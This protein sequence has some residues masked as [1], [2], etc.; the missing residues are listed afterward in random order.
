MAQSK[1]IQF[2]K[3]STILII[4]NLVIK[5]INFFLLPLYTKY[6]TP[7]ALGVSDTIVSLTSMIFPLLV[8]GLD[9]AFSAFYFDERSEEHQKRV[10]NT[11]CC[12]LCLLV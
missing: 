1:Q 10:F 11:I 7:E 2:L 5:G 9:S 4:S 8:M 3:G 6:L 12:T